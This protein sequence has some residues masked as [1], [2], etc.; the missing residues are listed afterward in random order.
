MFRTLLIF[1]VFGTAEIFGE[2][3]WEDRTQEFQRVPEDR[4]LTVNFAFRNKGKSPVTISKV[5]SSCDCTTA[6]LT[7]KTW[8]PGESGTLPARFVFGDRRGVQTKTIAVITD[9]GKTET[10][11]FRCHILADPLVLTPAFVSWRVGEAAQGKKIDLAIAKTA[12]M[13]VTSV[14]STNPRIT[15]KLAT[16][17][18]GKQYA[19]EIA[20]ADTS[21][22]ESAE[23]FVQTDF[24][25]E[26]PKAYTV[27]VRVK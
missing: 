10:L 23:I 7:K 24:P 9:D 22:P 5:T 18:D 12:K 6:G 17:E 13:R 1:L 19:V 15:A 3:V 8:Q 4:E 2:L 27:H 14:A 20:P 26:G 16:V 11:S 25:P 21:R